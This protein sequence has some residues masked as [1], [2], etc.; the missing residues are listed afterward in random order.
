M[1]FTSTLPS[2]SQ[3]VPYTYLNLIFHCSPVRWVLIPLVRW[4]KQGSKRLSNF[5]TQASMRSWAQMWL[6]SPGFFH[7]PQLSA[8]FHSWG[9]FSTSQSFH[10]FRSPA[11]FPIG[12]ATSCPELFTLHSLS[13]ANATIRL[14]GGWRTRDHFVG[15][16]VMVFPKTLLLLSFL[17]ILYEWTGTLAENLKLP[18]TLNSLSWLINE[19]DCLFCSRNS[20]FTN[21]ADDGSEK[22]TLTIF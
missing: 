18:V 3:S 6:S 22:R 13:L 16:I 15:E 8:V 17:S 10:L 1:V 4:R 2:H 9:S 14:F 12:M 20:Y 7:A 19:V 21:N 5:L 11:N